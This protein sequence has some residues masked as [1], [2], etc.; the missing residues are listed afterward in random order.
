MK[1]TQF[2]VLCIIA[3]ALT[4]A[5]VLS[6]SVED[7]SIQAPE[8]VDAFQCTTTTTQF[9]VTN[10][11]SFQSAYA[12][13]VDGIAADWAAFAPLQ[14]VL[15]PGQTQLITEALTI[16]CSKRGTKELVIIVSTTGGTEN[17]FIQSIDIQK[18][19]NID[20]LPTQYEQTI[21]PCGTA[22]YKVT[23][24]NP[25]DFEETYQL[26]LSAFEA[27]ARW[28]ANPVTVRGNS[29]A[30]ITLF[31][32]PTDCT[33]AGEF[34]LVLRASTKNTKIE[35]E[36]DL[37][38]TI[39][40][41]GI[42]EIAP[43]VR[44]IKTGYNE[45]K[46][47]LPISNKGNESIT[48]AIIVTGADW[49]T[50]ETANVTVAGESTGNITLRLKPTNETRAGTWLVVVSAKAD[51][52]SIEYKK[53]LTVKLIKPTF[54]NKIWERYRAYSILGIVVLVLVIIGLVVLLIHTSTP[55][56][57]QKAAERKKQRELQRKK[58]EEERKKRGAEENRK[59]Q[60]FAQWEQ[61][62]KERLKQEA[63]KE[64]KAEYKLIAKKEI[65]KTKAKDH[66]KWFWAILLVALLGS[67]AGTAYRYWSV[68]EQNKTH[69]YAGLIVVVVIVLVLFIVQFWSWLT[70]RVWKSGFAPSGQR[71][72]L[73]GWN[74]GI[75]ELKFTLGTPVEDA[76]ITLAKG[77]TAKI[78]AGEH[79]YK[80]YRLETNFEN[81]IHDA[82]C[83][84]KVA[85]SWLESRNITA[86]GVK[87][88]Q[89]SGKEWQGMRT[90]LV[91]EDAKFA[92]YSCSPE[93]P[94]EYA[95]VG[96]PLK[97]KKEPK[98]K[99]GAWV[100]LGVLLVIGAVVLTY[101]LAAPPDIKVPIQVKGIPP[102]SWFQDST[103]SIDLTQ[104]FKDPDN[105]SLAFSV[106]SGEHINVTIVNATAYIAPEKAWTGESYVVFAADD[107]K[108]GIVSSNAVKLVVKKAVIPLAWKVYAKPI[109]WG[110]LIL[111][112]L[113]LV[114]EF[115]KQ[116]W[117]FVA[118]D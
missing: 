18:P 105:D 29:N 2:L 20:I 104:Y 66:S 73:K 41:T 86:H 97:S 93:L 52:T 114:L 107:G 38:L 58:E 112:L 70:R 16:P 1:P 7:F 74:K 54:L 95:I 6:Q 64:L 56:Y 113:V 61:R 37:D 79:V 50:P 63:E 76:K 12:L 5:S 77:T 8:V 68:L 78:A 49:I 80:T 60:L 100:L 47:V 101:V 45:S 89:F 71:I 57:K 11:G 98:T 118:E 53:N 94:G 84:L 44:T 117:K 96:K 55:E 30:N 32:A 67:V 19:V 15:N 116:I 28:S 102:Q 88:V 51:K 110:V 65:A 115:R 46:A 35:A 83:T 40:K 27:Q 10:T 59:K 21:M 31:V 3:L 4:G 109:L 36:V 106:R 34:P 92:Y 22:T 62:E 85:K 91:S 42:A 25:F 103:H 69:V 9:S 48:Y 43:A 82:E 13:A 90:D 26:N 99:T 108:G 75:T 81:S 72:T 33:R 14:F 17:S 39:T 87:L 23:I 24:V 111:I